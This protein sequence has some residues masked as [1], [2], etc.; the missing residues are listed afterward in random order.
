MSPKEA[1]EWLWQHG[2]QVL[3]DGYKW[4]ETRCRTLI[5]KWIKFHG[6]QLAQRAVQAIRDKGPVEPVSFAEAGFKAI[7]A[8]TAHKH[9]PG[10][11]PQAKLPP[12]VPAEQRVRPERFAELREF[13]ENAK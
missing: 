2:W 3:A 7:H 5:G 9:K 6:P 4:P 8:R 12:E 1:Q 10:F 11:R 13:L